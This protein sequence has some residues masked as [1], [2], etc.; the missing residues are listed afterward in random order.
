MD[1]LFVSALELLAKGVSSTTLIGLLIY[2]LTVV[3]KRAKEVED[4]RDHDSIEREKVVTV[5]LEAVTHQMERGN[6]HEEVV[7]N[8]LK[9]ILIILDKQNGQSKTEN[10]D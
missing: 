8:T 1:P 2:A 4:K 10:K 5:A 7:A 3:W 6:Q 9:T